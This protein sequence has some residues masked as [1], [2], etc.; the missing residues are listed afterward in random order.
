MPTSDYVLARLRDR[1]IANIIDQIGSFLLILF[2][3]SFY[4]SSIKLFQIFG[5]FGIL[6][7]LLYMFSADG[8]MGGQ[9]FGKQ[10][11]KIC[12]I[13][14]NSGESCTF[15]KSFLRNSCLYSLGIIDCVFIFSDNRKRLGDIF[16]NT[17]VINKRP[18]SGS[19]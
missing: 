19:G 18:R 3:V 9:S 1:I 2:S 12:V 10:I 4:T 15:V 5:L 11:M 8:L 14:A 13:D 6:T 17:L 16:A 7:G